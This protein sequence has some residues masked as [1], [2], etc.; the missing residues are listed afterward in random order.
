MTASRTQREGERERKFQTLRDVYVTMY[1]EIS[2][3]LKAV[4]W[5]FAG[6]SYL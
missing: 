3:R 2:R 5:G 6:G 1:A 4:R